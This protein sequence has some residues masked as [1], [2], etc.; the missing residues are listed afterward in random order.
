MLCLTELPN[1]RIN[2]M[3]DTPYFGSEL[4]LQEPALWLAHLVEVTP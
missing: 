4:R 2:Q 3:L 1:T